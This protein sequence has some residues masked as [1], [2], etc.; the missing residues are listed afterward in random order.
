MR[1]AQAVHLAGSWH[2]AGCL[3]GRV[4]SSL[5]EHVSGGKGE[6][7]PLLG[8]QA[9]QGSPLRGGKS[10]WDMA[11]VFA[12]T[13]EPLVSLG[14]RAPKAPCLARGQVR[15][16][17]S[18]EP[19]GEFLGTG[20]P[21]GKGRAFARWGLQAVG[22]MDAVCPVQSLGRGLW[23]LWLSRRAGGCVQES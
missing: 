16:R 7:T 15:S 13:S 17:F 8:D 20:P 3:A 1:L 18:R 6:N 11:P 19:G 14:I 2:Q 22:R 21:H 10:Q 12:T 5:S 9:I 23:R 4:G